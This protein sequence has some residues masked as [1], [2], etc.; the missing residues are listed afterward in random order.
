MA[1][2]NYSNSSRKNL[3]NVFRIEV[4]NG[5]NKITLTFNEG[6]NAIIQYLQINLFTLSI[7][8]RNTLEKKIQRYR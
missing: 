5:Q 3:N 6:R 8:I 1:S 7:D 4:S 2:M